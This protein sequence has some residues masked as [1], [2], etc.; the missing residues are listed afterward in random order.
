MAIRRL[1]DDKGPLEL[2]DGEHRPLQQLE[3]A[4]ELVAARA[5]AREDLQL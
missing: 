5:L 1:N 3:R 2:L 4:L